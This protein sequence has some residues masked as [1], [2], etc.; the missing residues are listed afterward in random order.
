MTLSPS[1]SS[2]VMHFGEMG[3]RWGFNRTV[4]QMYALLVV[5]EQPLS[6]NDIAESLSISRGNV[7]MGL[8]E[9]QS[10]QLVKVSHQPGDRKEYFKALGSIWDMAKKVIEERRKREIDPTLSLLRTILLDGTEQKDSEHARQRL[11]E[12]HDLLESLTKW[13]NELQRLSPDNLNT[14]LKLSSGVGKVLDM[15]DKFIT[16]DAGS[17]GER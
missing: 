8:K 15:K 9:L 14:L 17:E 11:Q 12:I 7:S 3:S 5:S 4:G 13:S 10:W 6:A 2:F 16:R 1:L